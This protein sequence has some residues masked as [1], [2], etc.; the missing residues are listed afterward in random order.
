MNIVVLTATQTY[1]LY[2]SVKDVCFGLRLAFTDLGIN[3]DLRVW[4][5]DKI[6]L[7]PFL[8]QFQIGMWYFDLRFVYCWFQFLHEWYFA[9]NDVSSQRRIIRTERTWLS[10]LVTDVLSKLAKSRSVETEK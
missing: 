9:V 2:I 10:Y 3:G 7:N 1:V 8:E 4:N 6:D 5:L